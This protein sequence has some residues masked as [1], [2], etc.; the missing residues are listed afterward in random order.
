MDGISIVDVTHKE[1]VDA[2]KSVQKKVVL[3]VEMKNFDVSAL[4]VMGIVITCCVCVCT[5]M[6]AYMHACV[7]VHSLILVE[8]RTL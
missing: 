8:L 3:T 5:C 4:L 1:A 7:C 6:R 2:F